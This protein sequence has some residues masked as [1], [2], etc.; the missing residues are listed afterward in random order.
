M[1]TNKSVGNILR[2]AR[3]KKGYDQN[4]ISEL[5]KV[6]RVW[7]NYIENEKKKPGIKLAKQIS[8][9]LDIDWQIFFK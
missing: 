9:I 3:L 2:E 6:S 7:Y 5:L 4:E 1:K 8:K